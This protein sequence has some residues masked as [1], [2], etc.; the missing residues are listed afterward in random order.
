M[1]S[2]AASRR[3][4]C[5][6]AGNGG[7]AAGRW[8]RRRRRRAARR[9]RSS[10]R[11][12]LSSASVVKL[13]GRT[14]A[15]ASSGNGSLP[16][17]VSRGGAGGRAFQPFDGQARALRHRA[18]P[19]PK[20]RGPG[21]ST[22]R[23]PTVTAARPVSSPT[24]RPPRAAAAPAARRA[25]SRLPPAS[26]SSAGSAAVS[27]PSRSTRPVT[28]PK[29]E[30]RAS[31]R[32]APAPLAPRDNAGRAASSGGSARPPHRRCASNRSMIRSAAWAPDIGSN[33]GE[34]LRGGGPVAAGQPGQHHRVAA[35]EAIPGVELVDPGTPRQQADQQRRIAVLGQASDHA[36]RR[37]GP[38]FQRPR[39]RGHAA[40]SRR[41]SS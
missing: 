36:R 31:H 9:A 10:I 14:A 5:R 34:H 11:V 40:S 15:S 8:H 26:C 39:Q 23:S 32:R 7:S 35:G 4:H 29:V 24:G 21:R 12:I 1:R 19:E 18:R 25:S 33:A 37:R 41:P 2:A 16:T 20:G 17:R 27:R 3:R 38:R 22:R 6:S 30:R 13:S 28:G